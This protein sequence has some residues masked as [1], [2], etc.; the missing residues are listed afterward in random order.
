MKKKILILFSVI[1]A[2][3]LGLNLRPSFSIAYADSSVGHN[4][5]TVAYWNKQIT[6]N[7]NNSYDIVDTIK[8]QFGKASN[9][10][11]KGIYLAVPE[12]ETIKITKN[13][14]SKNQKFY[15]GVTNIK[16]DNGIDGSGNVDQLYSTY[17]DDSYKIIELGGDNYVNESGTSETDRLITYRVSYTYTFGND[18]T[19]DYDL[20]NLW[21]MPVQVPVKVEY[22][23]FEI[24]MPKNFT[25]TPVFHM[26]NV[27]T[28]EQVDLSAYIDKGRL[29]ISNSSPLEFDAYEGLTVRMELPQGYFSS[30]KN[31][32]I[33]VEIG[34][35]IGA[36]VVA[37][38][39]IMLTIQRGSKNKPVKTVEFYPPEGY[40]PCDCD[41]V[42]NG[43]FAP[44]RLVSLILYWASKGYVKINNDEK[45]KPK[46][47][48]K[49]KNLDKNTSAKF[50]E[51]ELFNAFFKNGDEFMLDGAAD[52][53]VCKTMSECASHVVNLIGNRYESGSKISHFFMALFAFVPFVLYEILAFSRTHFMSGTITLFSILTVVAASFAIALYNKTYFVEDSDG[54][55]N[56][57]RVFAIMLLV[58]AAVFALISVPSGYDLM[59]A[60]LL[61]LIP[62]AVFAVMG[63]NMFALNSELKENYGKL[64]GFKHSITIMDKS[65]IERLC[66]EDPS[67]FYDI[68]PYAYALNVL[69]DFVKNFESVYI[70]TGADYYVS[71]LAVNMLCHSLNTTFIRMGTIATAAGKLSSGGFKGSGGFGGFGGGGSF[72]GGGG[73][74][75]R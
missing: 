44:Q 21:L 41:Y 40:T 10:L 33:W 69:D 74:G 68:L 27:E 24:K 14:K 60:R 35:V 50:Y 2:L 64:W 72:S 15:L 11:H 4:N 59:A 47:I 66:K 30:V 17:S 25:T 13:G 51:I 56:M 71:P 42:I 1:F 28:V 23:K 12:V 8:V 18:F 7:D 9:G 36:V 53:R 70:P 54:K 73:M 26:G 38:I 57:P 46:S 52:E 49:L 58:V 29:T 45:Q 19:K 65:R 48:T 16:A 20:I 6:V 3:L 39:I 34:C 22:F 5:Y 61:T 55:M 32:S 31:F 43:S 63:K 37:V 75:G 62:V 67:Y